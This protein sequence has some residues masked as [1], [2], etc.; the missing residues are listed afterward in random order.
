MGA[1]QQPLNLLLGLAFGGLIVTGVLPTIYLPAVVWQALPIGVAGGLIRRW[2]LYRLAG[3]RQISEMVGGT[4]A[5]LSL[6]YVKMVAAIAGLLPRPL[7]WRR[8]PKFAR[9]GSGVGAFVAT[10]PEAAMALGHLALIVVPLAYWQELGPHLAPL[11]TVAIMLSALPFLWAP[12]M[13]YLSERA[14]AK[15]APRSVASPMSTVVEAP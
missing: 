5:H 2:H 4:V 1:L 10:A 3:C 8:T 6:N 12:L 9:A 11:A 15:R 14:L 7:R 13:A